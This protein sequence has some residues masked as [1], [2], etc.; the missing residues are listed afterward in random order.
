M[1]IKVQKTFN[2]YFI[3]IILIIVTL[4]ACL[5]LFI[6]GIEGHFGQ[7]LGFH[8]NRIE[9]I[10]TELKAGHFPVMM[11]S[12][13]MDGYGYP[14]AIYYGD[15][16][17]YIPALLRLLGIGVVT[18][19]KIYI[20]L[21]TF[22]TVCITYYCFKRII[23]RID[24]ALACSLIYTCA[25]YRIENVYIRAAVGEYSAMMFFPIVMLAMYLIYTD[26]EKYT[27]RK[28]FVNASVLTLGITGLINTHMLSTQIVG[29]VLIIFCLFNFKKTFT[30]NTLLTFV[31]AGVEIVIV[32]LFYLVPFVDYFIN[33]N[34]NITD[35]IGNARQIQES[36][37]HWWEFLAFFRMPFANIEE[38]GDDRLLVTPGIIC[39]LIL[40]AGIYLWIAGRASREMKLT[41]VGV[42]ILMFIAS[43]YF[44]WN[45][46]GANTRTGDFLA[47]VQFPW[48]YVGIIIIL[49]ALLGGRVLERLGGTD[50]SQNV[51]LIAS[52]V[53]IIA[54]SLVTMVWFTYQYNKYGELVTY[55]TAE[56]L[57][58]YD[59]G[60][61]EYLRSGTSREEFTGEVNAADDSNEDTANGIVDGEANSITIEELNRRGTDRDYLIQNNTAGGSITFPIVNY[62]GYE[63]ADDIGREYE[64]TDGD[65]NL[66]KIELDAE[67]NGML[68]I[69]YNQPWYWIMAEIISLM[70]AVI[71]IVMCVRIRRREADTARGQEG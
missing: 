34:V 20:A 45:Y 52:Y 25:F 18:S 11:E 63:V 10:V 64:I 36:G 31:C 30:R 69:L 50:R 47:Q 53:I 71:I 67:Y 66:I 54:A 23:G 57:D 44:P 17:L 12:N 41:I 28:S 59:M 6:S 68:Y 56:D 58:S 19:Y 5:P 8:L 26:K 55:E 61:I 39:I 40:A 4:I 32:N 15:S 24:I 1:E 38:A 37:L 51:A 46:L 48:R 62:R 14:V 65:N 22:G 2:K 43:C 7:D 70:G 3:L 13:W 9:G 33:E 60:Y 42:I 21:I 49:L 35:T 27:F 29:I 16:L